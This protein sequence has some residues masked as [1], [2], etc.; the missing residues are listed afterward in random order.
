MSALLLRFPL[1]KVIDGSHLPYPGLELWSTDFQ[2]PHLP[3]ELLVI[4][5][6]KTLG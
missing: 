1:T 4:S 6:L 2:T 5:T 3:A